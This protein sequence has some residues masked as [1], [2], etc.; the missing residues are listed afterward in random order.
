MST[1]NV[2]EAEYTAQPPA[3][4][5]RLRSRAR[6]Q[7]TNGAFAA[8]RCPAVWLCLLAALFYSALA[9]DRIDQHIP[10]S[11]DFYV[12]TSGGTAVLVHN[13]PDG[14]PQVPTV[15]QAISAE[16]DAAISVGA[17]HGTTLGNL[18]RGAGSTN[19]GEGG[20]RLWDNGNGS[21][22]LMNQ[23]QLDTV[24]GSGYTPDE[25]NTFANYFSKVAEAS[26]ARGT[27]NPSVQ[28]RA[29]LLNWYV[30]NWGNG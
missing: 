19:V 8:A 10:S 4:P 3:S 29:D 23:D 15:S 28:Q 7:L 12:V 25:L 17:D 22:D 21:L 9:V 2:T 24:R 11:Y 13:C 20:F 18:G 1:L 26:E 27:P 5:A 14:A 6:R 30:D 16:R